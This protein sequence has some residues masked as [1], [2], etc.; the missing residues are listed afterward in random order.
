MGQAEQRAIAHRV[1]QQLTAELEAFYRGVFDRMSQEHLGD[2]AMARLTQ[3]ILRSRDG[4]LSP[5][6][7]AMGSSPAPDDLQKGPSRNA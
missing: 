5:L 2:G 6:Q 4:A 1:Q 3:V 7:E